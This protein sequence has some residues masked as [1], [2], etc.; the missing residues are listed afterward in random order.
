MDHRISLIVINMKTTT[1]MTFG[2][3]PYVVVKKVICTGV[4]YGLGPG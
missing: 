2:T 1:E 3:V 4:L